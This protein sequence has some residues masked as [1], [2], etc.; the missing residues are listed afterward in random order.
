MKRIAL[1][2]VFA[3]ILTAFTASGWAEEAVKITSLLQSSE[4]LIGQKIAYPPSD[5]AEM[6]A[7]MVEMAPGA[8]IG[9]HMHPVPLVVYVMEGTLDV[10]VQDGS[11]HKIEAGKAFLEVINTWHNGI[12]RGE[13]PVKFL[14]VFAGEIGKDNLIRAEQ[15]K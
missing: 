11:K 2:S 5:K 10:D 9:L 7:L 8:E 6:A 1:L 13:M 15:K 12:N 14:V 4:T 3:F